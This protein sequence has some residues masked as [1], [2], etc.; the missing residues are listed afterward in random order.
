MVDLHTHSTASD[1]ALNPSELVGLAGKLGIKALA[2]TDHDSVAGVG[3]AREAAGEFGMIFV[4]GVEIEIAFSP[5][6]FH[7]LGLGLDETYPPLL[8]SL[9]A[10]A[11]SRSRRNRTI[12]DKLKDQGLAVDTDWLESSLPSGRMGRPHIAEAMVRGRQARSLQEAFDLYLGKGRP[13]YEP[14]DCLDLGDALELIRKAGGVPVVAHPYSLFVSKPKL[15]SLMA[16]WKGMG[17]RGI[18]AYHPGAKLG[19]CRI[20]ERMGRTEGFFITAGSDFHSPD[21]PRWG[22]GKTAGGIPIEDVYFSE[23]SSAMASS[24]LSSD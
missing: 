17:V 3:E 21:K 19:Q 1:G 8:E 20:L 9:E 14:K 6:E 7:L 15:S 5:G 13:Y 24:P 12:L 16:E 10:L 23:L 22:L 11:L 2:L 18:E 4:A